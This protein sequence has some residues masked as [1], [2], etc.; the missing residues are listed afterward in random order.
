[1][2]TPTLAGLH[3]IP[4]S[5]LTAHLLPM[6]RVMI[7]NNVSPERH[8]NLITRG[9]YSLLI[10]IQMVDMDEEMFRELIVYVIQLRFEYT[11]VIWSPNRKKTYK[12]TTDYAKCSN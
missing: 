3:L 2:A 5:I 4:H 1:M 10:N 11:V 6:L 12:K 7:Q 8:I 9:T